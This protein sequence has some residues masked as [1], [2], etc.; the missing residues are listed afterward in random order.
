MNIALG[1]V[2]IMLF[3]GAMMGAVALVMMLTIDTKVDD[4]GYMTAKVTDTEPQQKSLIQ[5]TL[6][7]DEGGMGQLLDYDDTTGQWLVADAQ[8]R[9]IDQVSFSAN[10][11]F[12]NLDLAEVMR[13]DSGETGT[14]DQVDMLTTGGH[15]LRVW[16]SIGNLEVKWAG[17]SMWRIVDVDS[18]SRRLHEMGMADKASMDFLDTPPRRMYAKGGVVIVGGHHRGHGSGSSGGG[19]QGRCNVPYGTKQPCQDF[20]KLK[21]CYDHKTA[22]G[23]IT[24]YQ[25]HAGAQG[26]VGSLVVLGLVLLSPMR[27]FLI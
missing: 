26:L 5:T 1:M 11:S 16:S 13:I 21:A 3:I 12:F 9:N 24:T 22:T 8:L 10:S 17:T 20:C 14:N 18:T 2:V 4:S 23:Q 7:R 19:C 25:C 15:R 6:E 27:E